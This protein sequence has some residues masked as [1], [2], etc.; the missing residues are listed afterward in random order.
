DFAPNLVY[1]KIVYGDRLTD[2]RVRGANPRA[3][4]EAEVL[5]T[6][7]RRHVELGARAERTEVGA[8]RVA[9]EPAVAVPDRDGRQPPAHARLSR[10]RLCLGDGRG[11]RE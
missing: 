6:P 2:V 5:H 11:A 7:H 10:A 8:G 3:V 4:A 1:G 9:A